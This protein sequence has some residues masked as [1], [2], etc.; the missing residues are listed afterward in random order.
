M[1]QDQLSLLRLGINPINDR[2]C[3]NIESGLLWIMKNT[4]LKFNID[5][6]D[7]LEALPA[8]VRLFLVKYNEIMNLRV[9]IASESISNLSQ[10]FNS[11]DINSLIWQAAEEL[12][13]DELKSRATFVSAANRWR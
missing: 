12:L 11:T 7:D 2:T 4:T 3:L 5:N 1:T 10:S 6:D 13:S 8:N 9:G